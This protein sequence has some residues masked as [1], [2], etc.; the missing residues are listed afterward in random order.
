MSFHS[1]AVSGG[2]MET[3]FRGKW[4]KNRNKEVSDEWRLTEERKRGVGGDK[5]CKRG[6]FTQ[7]KAN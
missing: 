6:N 5:R 2:F 3:G 4:E 1:W 7:R